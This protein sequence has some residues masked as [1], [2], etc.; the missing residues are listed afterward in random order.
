MLFKN[1]A[2]QKIHVYAYDS[3]TGAAKTGDAGNITG[4]VSLDGTANAIDDTNPAEVDSTNMPGLYV[5]DLTQAETN[6][7][8]FALVAKSSTANIRI[9][10]IIGFTTGAAVTQTGDAFARLGA[11][12][13]ASV[14]A[15]IA[16]RLAT[17]GYTAPP[18]ASDIKTALEAD[19]S[20]LDHLW[21]MT[22]DDA[23]TRRFTENALE[24]APTAGGSAPTVEQIR[25]EMDANSTKLAAI[26]ADTNELQTD[27]ANGGRLD[28]LIDAIKAKTDNLPADPADQSAVEAAITAATSPLATAA[29]LDAVG[30]YVDTE[31][32]AILADTNELQ[33][34]LANGGRLDLLIDAIKAKTDN[35]PSDPADQSAVEAAITA[36]T[37]PLATAAA[38]DAV[39]N[40]V[41]TEVAAIKAVTDK[42]DSA[43]ELDGEVYRF[44]ANALE[45]APSGG[46]APTA[47]QVADAVWDEVLDTAHEVAGSASV[48]LQASGDAYA[49]LGAPAGASVSADIAAV[50][51]ETASII[52]DTNELQTDLTNGGR[53]D[54]LIDAILED[55]AVIGAAG[56]GLTAIPWNAAWDAEVQSECADALNTYDPPTNAEM[57]AAIPAASAVADAVWD[58]AISG[59]LTAGTTGNAL[60]AAG[61]AGDPWSTP[62]PG[63]YGAGTAGKI[64]GD[65]INAT[66]SSRSSHSA[67]DIKTAM[68]ADGGKLD[69]LWEMTEDD[70]G[71]RRLTTN[72]LELAPS[73]GSAPTAAQVA[74]AVWDEVL[75]TAHEV[76]GSASV[77]LQASGAAG[78]PMSVAVPGAYAEGTAGY[79]IG[80]LE[81]SGSGSVYWPY[82]VTDSATGN[83]IAGVTVSV[84]TDIAGSVVV[85]SGTTNASGVVNFNL[86]PGTYYLWL[87]KTG[88][89]F[90][91]PDTEVIA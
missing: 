32:A 14:S 53:V 71:T 81:S 64:V 77:L 79:V 7:D 29:A 49:R 51:A 50:K 59:H 88:Y 87:S 22:E 4:Y 41:D 17:S 63:A 80:H 42:L 84:S 37:S 20:K 62:I 26:L 16:T 76:A 58:E 11:P 78:D 83:P 85:A 2:S 69:H 66:I 47:A 10:P 21:E 27:L 54:L 6:C 12:A 45:L 8:A 9:E 23:G 56:A 91:N 39:D 60:N 13:G 35:L 52:A 15:D 90:T 61:S 40:Y 72:A 1:V 3:T 75:D 70:G 5:F 68:E 57:I 19:G 43:V 48:L 65:N 44:T 31:V 24:Q 18:S 25:A 89:T 67:A 55:T 74:D 28:L 86:D 73:G 30:Y 36:A 82:T 38:L 33:T 34:D 46:S